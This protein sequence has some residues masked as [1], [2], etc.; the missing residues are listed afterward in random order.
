[1]SEKEPSKKTFW[2]IWVFYLLIAFEIIYMI[3]PFG[4]YYYSVYGRGLNFLNDNSSTAWLSSFFLPHIVE[5]SSL[6]LNTHKDVGWML[7]IIG[8]LAF[9]I[10]AGQI[11]YYKFAKKGAVT[12]GI[13]NIMRHPQ[14]ISL[15]ICSFGL[16]LFWPRYLVLIMFITMLLKKVLEI[17]LSNQEVRNR[18]KNTPL[19]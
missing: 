11:Y 16:L 7:A 19:F 14:Y 18:L 8:F 12:G 3:S 2:A 9:C 4:I 10:G 5:T 1:M 17:A 13:Y 15:A 6:V